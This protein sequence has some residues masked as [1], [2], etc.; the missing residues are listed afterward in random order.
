MILRNRVE[1]KLSEKKFA[2]LEKMIEMRN[3][4][5]QSVGREAEKE[6]ETE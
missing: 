4:Y 6:P 2:K 3:S 1:A 5:M